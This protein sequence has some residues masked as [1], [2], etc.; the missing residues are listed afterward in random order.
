MSGEGSACR[1]TLDKVARGDVVE[2]TSVQRPE[3]RA[4]RAAVS[5]HAKA[6]GWE[7]GVPWSGL[8]VSVVEMEP[9]S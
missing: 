5:A 3:G 1:G 7:L 9:L 8:E 2:G 6:L 4:S